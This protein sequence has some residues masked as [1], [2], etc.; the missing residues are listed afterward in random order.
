MACESAGSVDAE[1]SQDLNH[2]SEGMWVNFDK[3]ANSPLSK[4]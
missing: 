3:R 4:A 2:T 1:V